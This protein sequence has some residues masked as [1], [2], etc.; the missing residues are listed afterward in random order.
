MQINGV[1]K[2]QMF[3]TFDGREIEIFTSK[4]NWIFDQ[5]TETA[6][7]VELLTLGEDFQK[8][9]AYMAKDTKLGANIPIEG[10]YIEISL[11]GQHVYVFMGGEMVFDTPCVTG[12][13]ANGHSTPSGIYRISYLERDTYLVGPDWKSFV[14]YWMPFNG[15]IGLHDASWRGS[16]GGS[17]Y[18]YNGS[19]GCVNLPCDAAATIYNMIY[20]GM[21]VVA[22]WD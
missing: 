21:P 5:Q 17:I 7:L 14:N 4:K 22:Y 11:A 16:F 8:E 20:P 3:T 9:P 19:H 1:S 13:V 10:D 18:Y 6:E 2:S 15:S 12:C